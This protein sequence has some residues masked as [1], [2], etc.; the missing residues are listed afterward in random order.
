MSLLRRVAGLELTAAA[1]LATPTAARR[2]GVRIDTLRDEPLLAAL[3][4]THPYANAEKIPIGAFATEPILLPREPSGS[5]FNAWLRAVVRAA[6]FELE[7]TLETL[8]A[9]WD[10]RMLPVAAG[11]AVSALVGEWLQEPI[12]GVSAIPFDPPLN[13]PIDLASSPTADAELLVETACALRD[14]GGWLTQRPARTELP[15]D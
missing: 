13:F 8:S 2:Y 6:G 10:R 4:A 1:V 12:A 7:R 11:E 15:N 3:P 5:A 14:A 9:P